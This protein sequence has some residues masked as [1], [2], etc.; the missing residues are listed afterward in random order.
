MEYIYFF[1][2]L[3]SM[4]REQVFQCINLLKL[5]MEDKLTIKSI[6]EISVAIMHQIKLVR[7]F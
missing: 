1:M 7:R 3:Q 6:E 2:N 4:N 5:S